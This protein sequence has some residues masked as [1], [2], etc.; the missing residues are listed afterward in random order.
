MSAALSS[1]A[2]VFYSRIADDA[3]LDTVREHFGLAA[4]QNLA[5]DAGALEIFQRVLD[6]AKA[7]IKEFSP[8]LLTPETYAQVKAAMNAA[9]DTAFA[10]ID[11]PGPDI[12]IEPALRMMANWALDRAYNFVISGS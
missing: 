1:E 12:V 8:G 5:A 6:S 7:L 10:T 2:Q 11:F 9:L 4:G 3:G